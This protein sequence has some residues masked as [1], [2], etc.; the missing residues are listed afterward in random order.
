MNRLITVKGTGNVSVKPDLI[1]ITMNLES[2]QYD[3]KKTMELA[4]DSVNALQDA[5]HIA[6]FNKKDLKTTSF[7]IRTHYESY[8]DENNNYKSKFDGYICEQG[9]KLEFDFNTEVM[10]KVLTAIAKAPI[11]P[12]LNIQFSVKDKA[13]VNEELLV[14]ATENAKRKAD[15]LT[16]ASGV[17][18]GDLISIDYN[19]GELHLYS[20]TRYDMEDRCMVM[21]ES[22]SPDIEP[23]DIDVS[24]TVSFVWEI[25]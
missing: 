5:I 3:Y 21:A 22:C 16:K 2:H 7:N 25:K 15:I 9:L 13:A 20:P 11:D 23:D 6:G 17:T 4:T 1:I 8:R 10:S 24:D 18:L 19:W 14:S 12:K